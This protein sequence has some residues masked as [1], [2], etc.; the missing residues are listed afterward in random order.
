MR[1]G[2]PSLEVQCSKIGL[3]HD[4][5]LHDP[6][7]AKDAAVRH[8]FQRSS[9]RSFISVEHVIPVLVV[10]QR[11]PFRHHPEVRHD[12][13][14]VDFNFVR[15]RQQFFKEADSKRLILR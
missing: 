9:R 2:G 5:R 12:T 7:W 4:P 15:F 11:L 1:V 3:L 14:D 8:L 13:V 6:Y 10:K